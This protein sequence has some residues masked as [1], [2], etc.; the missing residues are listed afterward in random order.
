MTYVGTAA[1]GCQRVQDPLVV[2]QGSNL[3]RQQLC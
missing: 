3:G 2:L 1:F